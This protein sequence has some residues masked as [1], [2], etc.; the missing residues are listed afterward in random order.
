MD[1][2]FNNIAEIGNLTCLKALSI[3]DFSHNQITK[4]SFSDFHGLEKLYDV[5]LSHNN[6]RTLDPGT[7]ATLGV[8]FLDLSHNNLFS[9]DFTNVFV[10]KSFC[11]MSFM[12]NHISQIINQ[13]KID[14]DRVH[15]NLGDGFMID[16]RNNTM[17]NLPRP[18]TFGLKSYSDYGQLVFNRYSM[19]MQGNPIFFDCQVAKLL[20]AVYSSP[21]DNIDGAGNGFTCTY[22]QNLNGYS[23]ENDI[24]KKNR[25][26]LLICQLNTTECPKGCD[27]YFQPYYNRSVINCT[28]K[29][30]GNE[31]P[32]FDIDKLMMD[33]NDGEPTHFEL[34]FQGNNLTKIGEKNYARNVTRL[35]LSSNKIHSIRNVDISFLP[36][37]CIIS[38]RNNTLLARIPKT[39]E[40]MNPNQ[41]DFSNCYIE[42]DCEVRR[43]VVSWLEGYRVNTSAY[44]LKCKIFNLRFEF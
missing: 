43:W 20:L 40:K 44:S 19:R 28:S 21:E 29:W 35:D 3:V 41:I 10:P 36:S 24:I 31:L 18:K 42:C 23:I 22:P 14:V 9:I 11:I 33:T 39:F 2:S 26:D 37:D 16:L 38:L 1:V 15:Y 7:F 27:C 30:S 34:F 25:L 8:Q 12:N 5:N 13:N 4:I 32:E 17:S 6:I